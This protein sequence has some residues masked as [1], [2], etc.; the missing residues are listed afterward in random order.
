MQHLSTIAITY[1]SGLILLTYVIAVLNAYVTIEL[2][3][4][5]STV[6]GRAR[7]TWLIGGAVAIGGGVWSMYFIGMLTLQFALPLT[8]RFPL[9]ALSFL[10]MVLASGIA[11]N[12][13]RQPRLSL[14]AALGS[15]IA[16]GFGIA[17][18]HSS[19]VNAIPSADSA[20]YQLL[21][22]L[23]FIVGAIGTSILAIYL[24]SRF[25]AIQR[26]I[27]GR[28][29][30]KTLCALAIGIATAGA[31]HVGICVLMRIPIAEQRG[32]DKLAF[33]TSA[34]GVTIGLAALTTLS[35]VLVS[36]LADRR[37]V[38]Q[39]AAFES[40]FMCHPDAVYAL[41]LKGTIKSA[42]PAAAAMTGYKIDELSDIP[43]I[44]QIAAENRSQIHAALFRT[45]A[46]KAQSYETTMI[47]RTGQPILLSVMHVPIILGARV[48]GLYG[49]MKDITE[50]VRVE[51]QR[52]QAEAALQE[53]R[54][55]LSRRVAERTAELRAANQELERAVRLKDEFLASVSHELRTPL[56][57]ILGLS[58]SLQEG[59]YGPVNLEQT[60]A[61]SGIVES[62][63]HLLS[64]IN[65]ILDLS[66][67]EAGK[68]TLSLDEVPVTALCEA[69]LR[70]I[71]QPALQ[72]CIAVSL[73][74]DSAVTTIRGD[75]RRL[76]QVL[77]NLLSNAV[78]FTPEGG[79]IGL[80]VTADAQHHQVRLTVWDTGIGIAAQDYGRLFQPFIQLDS[81]L[82]RQYAGT[83]LGLALVSTMVK[84]H[85]GSVSVESSVGGGS[86]FCV[87]LP[88]EALPAESAI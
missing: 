41:D 66:K 32:S 57:A 52:T 40:L 63:K 15:G 81:S 25:Y 55:L 72:K 19:G 9:V 23:F 28:I 70:L 84:L 7:T 31:Q 46:G 17:I 76:K 10:F 22:S 60:T 14:R 53:E 39:A 11:L 80:E 83:G 71:R 34:L 86:R 43:F 3:A 37:L 56:N 77:V 26:L 68:V 21:P 48:V 33:N 18:I 13:I 73:S 1:H 61:L 29:F 82:A 5:V 36:M 69:S 38:A 79:A 74:T 27:K 62:G 85:D 16:L 59:I 67:I 88:W 64:L 45:A 65:D 24:A 35:I 50:H 47:T 87:A 42:N 75:P 49:L 30:L 8:Y 54:S 2:A 51:E 58:E 20:F 4:R 6:R 78:K 12:C 44:S